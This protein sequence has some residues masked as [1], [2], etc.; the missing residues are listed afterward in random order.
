MTGSST[1]RQTAPEE[2]SPQGSRLGE[3]QTVA[4]VSGA[5]RRLRG[6]VLGVLKGVLVCFINEMG[7]MQRLFGLRNQGP[8]ENKM[9][10]TLIYFK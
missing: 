7:L 5:R 2:Q 9:L 3:Q 4:R 1:R 8:N 10:V 6:Q